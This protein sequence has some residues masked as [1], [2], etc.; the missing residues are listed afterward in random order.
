MEQITAVIPVQANVVWVIELKYAERAAHKN[1]P[2]VN[3]SKE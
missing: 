3:K 2:A 1:V